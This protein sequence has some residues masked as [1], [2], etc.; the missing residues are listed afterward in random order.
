MDLYA[1]C[2]GVIALV[3]LIVVWELLLLIGRVCLG[4]VAVLLRRGLRD[5]EREYDDAP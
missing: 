5:N 2:A 4:L 3:A 1:F